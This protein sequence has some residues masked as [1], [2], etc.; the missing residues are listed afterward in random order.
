MSKL[1]QTWI[2][3]PHGR[4][5]AI[6]DGILTVPAEIRM[7]LGNFPRRMTVVALDGGRVAIW[8]AVPLDEPSMRRIEALG[9]VSFLI[10]PGIAHRLDIQPW[11]HRFPEALVVCPPGARAKVEE[12]VPVDATSDLLDDA[13]V[14]LE[15]APGVGEREAILRVRRGTR[16]TLIVNDLLANVREPHGV[17]AHIMARLLGFGVDRPRMPRIGKRLFVEDGAALAGGMRRWASDPSLV[18]IVVSHGEVIADEPRR[19]LLV[20][21]DDLDAPTE[22]RAASA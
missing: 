4:L 15:I 22:K 9:T 19:A 20:A 16:T 14:S 5:E 6:D 3:A 11:K 21:A 18:R 7:P 17:G 13:S 12:A 10:V 1:N 2:V 8:S